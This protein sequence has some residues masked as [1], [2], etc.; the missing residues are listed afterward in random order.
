MCILLIL[1][2]RERF[3]AFLYCNFENMIF[4]FDYFCFNFWVI[5]GFGLFL[6]NFK[7]GSID[8]FK[9]LPRMLDNVI[10]SIPKYYFHWFTGT[11][12]NFMIRCWNG[13]KSNNW[14]FTNYANI[15]N[16]I[17]VPYSYANFALNFFYSRNVF[18]TGGRHTQLFDYF[19]RIL[20]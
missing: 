15:F 5:F 7:N 20:F 14:R 1:Q 12:S 2:R 8:F 11:F 17:F 10:N 16:G 19:N 6:K 13:Q 9:R 3:L 4:S 18:F